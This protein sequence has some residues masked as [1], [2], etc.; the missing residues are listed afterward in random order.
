MVSYTF[1]SISI[2][3][4]YFRWVFEKYDGVRGFWNPQKKT[5][6]SRRGRMLPFPQEIIDAMPQDIF[7]DGELWYLY[8]R[9]PPPQQ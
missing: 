7:L 1:L 8:F 6:Y 2:Y 3:S 5:F 9:P 4:I